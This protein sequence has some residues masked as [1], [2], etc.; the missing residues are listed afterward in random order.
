VNQLVKDQITD[1]LIQSQVELALG[2]AERG[3]Q[4]KL[5]QPSDQ[6]LEEQ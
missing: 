6:V 4:Q 3:N 2:D 5:L 1:E